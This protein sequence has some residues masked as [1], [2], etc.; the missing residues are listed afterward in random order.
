MLLVGGASEEGYA[1]DVAVDLAPVVEHSVCVGD[2]GGEDE[3][4]GDGEEGHRKRAGDDDWIGAWWLSVDIDVEEPGEDEV[5]PTQ[6]AFAGN[7]TSQGKKR[8]LWVD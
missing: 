5:G 3:L 7:K 6:E 1:A 8:E 4:A 2:D